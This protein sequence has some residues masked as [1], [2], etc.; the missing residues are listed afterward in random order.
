MTRYVLTDTTMA[1]LMAV[2]LMMTGATSM[3][4]SL[5]LEEPSVFAGKWQATLSSTVDDLRAQKLQ[6]KPSNTCSVE[7]L[8]NKTVGQ[9]ADCLG[10]WLE[11]APIGWFP[12]PDG[13]S[14]TGHEGSRIQFFSRQRDGLY[15]ATLKSGLIVTL[16]RTAPDN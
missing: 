3:A 1:W 6:D 5:R 13:L 16:E 9:G 7:L 2:T 10:A 12:D 8:A 11:Q 15:L 4:S 14:I